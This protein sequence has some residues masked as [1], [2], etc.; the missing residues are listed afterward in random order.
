MRALAEYTLSPMGL[1]FFF[2]I[3]GN[4]LLF[5]KRRW[6]FGRAS[7]LVGLSLL[8]F[9][10]FS[11]IK[12]L[13]LNQLEY[14]YAP[15]ASQDA[16]GVDIIVLLSGGAERNLNRPISSQVTSS[17]ISRLC[18]AIRLFLL[19]PSANL[20]ISGGGPSS[21]RSDLANSSVIADLAVSLGVPRNKIICETRSQNTYESALY[22]RRYVGSKSFILVTSAMHMPRAMSV[23]RRLGMKPIAAGADYRSTKEKPLDLMAESHSF[24]AWLRKWVAELPNAQELE[25][26]TDCL[27]EFFGLLWYRIVG[28]G[29][30]HGILAP[31]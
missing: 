5:S 28:I 17:S 15:I 6:K 31:K 1:I 14:I 19:N 8:F 21:L 22:V 4:V 2:L 27:H 18:E 9:F 16:L 7:V 25:D 3:C 20:L 24:D 11:P 10:S 30:S 26:F 23:F 13:F 29:G 12:D